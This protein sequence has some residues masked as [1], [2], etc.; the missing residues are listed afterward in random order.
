MGWVLAAA[1]QRSGRLAPRWPP[2]LGFNLV[3]V[4]ALFYA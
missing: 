3:G 1:V 2:T 4:L